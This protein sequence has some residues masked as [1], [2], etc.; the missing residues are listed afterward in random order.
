MRLMREMIGVR[1][2]KKVRIMGITREI[3]EMWEM[4]LMKEMREIRMYGT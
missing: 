4:L 2:M 1:I 3:R